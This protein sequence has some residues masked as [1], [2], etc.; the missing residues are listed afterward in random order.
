M[1]GL[2]LVEQVELVEKVELVLEGL[3]THF[4]LLKFLHIHATD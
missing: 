2:R 4:G 3:V 1:K